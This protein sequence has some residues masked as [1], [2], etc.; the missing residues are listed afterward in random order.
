MVEQVAMY[1]RVKVSFVESRV[2]VYTKKDEKKRG[3]KQK[4]ALGK[5]KLLTIEY[6]VSPLLRVNARRRDY[7]V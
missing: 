1:F 2:L 7:I 5:R 6:N 4:N 3:K